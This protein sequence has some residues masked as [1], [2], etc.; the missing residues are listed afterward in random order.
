MEDLSQKTIFFDRAVEI[1][2][3]YGVGQ[4]GIQRLSS[5][6]NDKTSS[7]DEM[8]SCLGEIS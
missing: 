3:F 1:S 5:K 6:A 4:M 2:D 7:T 8:T